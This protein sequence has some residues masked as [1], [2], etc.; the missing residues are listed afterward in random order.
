MITEGNV[1]VNFQGSEKKMKRT[2]LKGL[3]EHFS[4]FLLAEGT[5]TLENFG[6]AIH[7]ASP[8][9]S[10]YRHQDQGYRYFQGPLLTTNG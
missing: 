4:D 5:H 9:T 2:H 1:Y 8:P 7:R 10:S 6:I 3:R